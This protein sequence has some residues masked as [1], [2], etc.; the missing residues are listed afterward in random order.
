VV[1]GDANHTAAKR[2]K[3]NNQLVSATNQLKILADDAKNTFNFPSINRI[4]L[5]NIWG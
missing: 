4:R 2:E 3:E 5:L 1:G